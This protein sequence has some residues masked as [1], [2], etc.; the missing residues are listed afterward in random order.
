VVLAAIQDGDRFWSTASAVST[1]TVLEVVSLEVVSAHGTVIPP[2]G[3]YD[4]PVGSVFTNRLLDPVVTFGE[5]Q[6]VS[7]GWTGT[8]LTPTSGFGTQALVTVTQGAVLTWSWS[9]NVWLETLPEPNGVIDPPS[10][11]FGLGSSVVVT[12]VADPYYSFE[13]WSGDLAGS[14]NP[15]SLIMTQPRSVG[16]TFSANLTTNTGT[17]EWWLASFGLTNDFPTEALGD[18]D[19]DSVATWEEYI[20][21]TV[22][23]NGASF[24]GFRFSQ[25]AMSGL[26][27]T[28]PGASGRVYDLEVALGATNPVWNPVPGATNL[29]GQLPTNAVTVS[30]PEPVQVYRVRVRVS[31]N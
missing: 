17:P 13:V 30:G 9:T 1:V 20:A 6:L 5:T 12:A 10:G 7:S 23:T 15:E 18:P 31:G 24:L 11:W 3:T 8:G 14:V 29:A 4:L 27:L 22:P 26:T 25:A 21:A 28:W 2:A 19:G 16:A